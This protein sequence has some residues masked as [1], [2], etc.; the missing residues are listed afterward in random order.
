MSEILKISYRGFGGFLALTLIFSFAVVSFSLIITGVACIALAIFVFINP[1]I[2]QTVTVNFFNTRITD[3]TIASGIIFVSA[4][5]LILLGSV[6][7]VLTNGI[8]NYSLRADKGISRYVDAN[9]PK[10]G[11]L[12]NR[13]RNSPE[14]T[15]KISKLERLGKLRQQGVL[16]EAE[17]EQE[18][19]LI[20]KDKTA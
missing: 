11:T 2:L 13:M 20:L 12:I 7:L 9:V 10:T 3:P 17:F 4:I 19:Q 14:P 6:F 1:D 5:V 8:W 15:D 18:K 16:T